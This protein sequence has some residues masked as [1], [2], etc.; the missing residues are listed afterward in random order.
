MRF[1]AI[2]SV[3]CASGE[4][5]PSDMAEETNR[6]RIASAGSTSSSG[7]GVPGRARRA[8]RAGRP[9]AA[10]PFFD[11]EAAVRRRVPPRLHRLLQRHHDRRCPAV[12][13]ALLPEADPA[14]VGQR[15]P[16]SAASARVGRAVAR[17]HV[18]RDLLEADAADAARRCPSKQAPITSWPRPS[19]SKICAPQ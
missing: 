3:A 13:L 8:G 19:T 4:S 14:V 15:D 18:L 16:T 12:V 7:T 17:Q 6:V 11:Q 5:A 2:D 10:L 9:A 1:I